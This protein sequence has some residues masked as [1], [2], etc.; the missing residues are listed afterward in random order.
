MT[1]LKATAAA[2]GELS[3]AS[4]SRN[5]SSIAELGASSLGPTSCKAS[6]ICIINTRFKSSTFPHRGVMAALAQNGAG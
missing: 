3:S 1:D 4:S 2:E 5:A 6:H